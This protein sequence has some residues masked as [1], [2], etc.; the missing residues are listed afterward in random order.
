M[1]PQ[2][3]LQSTTCQKQWYSRARNPIDPYD[4]WV[5]SMRFVITMAA[6]LQVTQLTQAILDHA[7]K[8]GVS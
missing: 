2:R 7:K 1:W 6:A 3:S 5:V 4:F 8:N